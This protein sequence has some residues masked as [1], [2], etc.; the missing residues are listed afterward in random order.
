MQ[1]R[2]YRVGDKFNLSPDALDNYG[3]VAGPYTIRAVYTHYCKPGRM[4]QDP[5]GHPGFD[6]SAHSAL[7]GSE[8]PFDVYEWE[9]KHVS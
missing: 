3:V 9:M 7:Y 5:T 4:E 6:S 2:S 1:R 8:L